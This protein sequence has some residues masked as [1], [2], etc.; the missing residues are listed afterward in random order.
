M[1]DTVNTAA[2]EAKIGYQ[3]KDLSL[4]EEA[5]THSS[6]ANEHGGIKKHRCNERLEFLGDAV[7]SSVTAEFLFRKYFDHPEGELTRMRAE[8]VCEKALAEYAEKY[9]VN[10]GIENV[11]NKLLLSPLETRDFI[12]SESFALLEKSKTEK[13]F[14]GRV[15][16]DAHP[17]LKNRA[18]AMIL[19]KELDVNFEVLLLFQH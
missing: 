15:L 16:K 11:G 5:L 17:A 14:D 7:L 9:N 3:F 19:E 12:D 13:G 6:Y 4:L 18:A 8:L 10:L 2:L 1:C